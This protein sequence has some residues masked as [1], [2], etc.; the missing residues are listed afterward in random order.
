MAALLLRA[1]LLALLLSPSAFAQEAPPEDLPPAVA[2]PAPSE[3]APPASAPGSLTSGPAAAQPASLAVAAPPVAPHDLSPWGMFAAAHPVVQ[4]VMVLLAGASFLTWTVLLFKAAE[5]AF[6]GRRL[7]RSSRAI[8]GAASLGD[9]ATRLDR[10]LDPAAFMARAALEELRRSDAA[11]DAAGTAGLKDRV[12]SILDRVDAQ[13]AERLRRGIGLLATIG[14]TAPF[15]GLFGTVW[16]IMNAFI[17]ISQSQ[18]TS[19]AVVAPGIAEA[20]LATA[21]GLVAAIP[22][23][24]VYNHFVRAIAAWRLRLADAGASI[25]RTLSRD[26]DFRTAG[27]A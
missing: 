8:H 27:R 17:G 4:G 21:M 26:L 18:T 20:L 16:G 3:A 24:I 7:A 23:V 10:R 9:A 2:A 5:L 11:L 19:L 14:S 15:I 13:A 1:T 25:E 22:A 12:R 6:A